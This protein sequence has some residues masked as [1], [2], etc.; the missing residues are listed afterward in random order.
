MFPTFSQHVTH[1]PLTYSPH[2]SPT[3]IPIDQALQAAGAGEESGASR[4]ML[5]RYVMHWWD[6]W[7]IPSGKQT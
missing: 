1:F 6:E 4:L 5:M 7:N 2:I 3:R